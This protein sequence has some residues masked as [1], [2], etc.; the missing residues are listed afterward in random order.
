[1][2]LQSAILKTIQ[3]PLY[4]R[5]KNVVENGPYHDHEDVFSHSVKAKDV[6]LE[7]ISADFILNPEAKKRFLE[8][9]EEDIN[10]IKRR[11]VMVLTALLHDVGKMLSINEG[12]NTRPLISTD[13]EGRTSCPGHEYWGSTIVGQIIRD[14][15]FPEE[16]VGLI[17]QIIKLHDNFGADYFGQRSDWTMEKLLNDVK[18]RAEGLYK[19]A[20][21][22]IY[23]DCFS[24]APFQ[25]SKKIIIKIFNEPKLYERREYV[26]A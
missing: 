9:T 11:D 2:D 26:L 20:L 14:L 19:E 10:G 22:N 23:C 21:F 17:S 18:S 7:A 3:N 13:S 24:A 1:M 15:S 12:G 6:A 5:L 16:V 25:Q 4:L 8:F